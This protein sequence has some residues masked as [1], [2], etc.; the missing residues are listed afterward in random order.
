MR[1]QFGQAQRVEYHFNAHG[2]RVCLQ[3]LGNSVESWD[4]ATLGLGEAIV[5]LGSLPPF[6][7]RFAGG[8][9]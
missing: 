7:F 8:N 2:E 6:R 3:R 4:L 5:G 1:R 9:S